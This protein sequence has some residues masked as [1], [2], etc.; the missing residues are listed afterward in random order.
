MQVSVTQKAVEKLN[1][2]IQ[3][4]EINDPVLRITFAGFG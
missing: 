2:A 1:D 3:S 4:S